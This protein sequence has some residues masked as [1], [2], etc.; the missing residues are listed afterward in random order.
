MALGTPDLL[1]SKK[2]RDIIAQRGRWL[3]PEN[4]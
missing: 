2:R 3:N 4:P 1:T